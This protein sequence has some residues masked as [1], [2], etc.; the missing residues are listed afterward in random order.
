MTVS[1]TNR[2]FLHAALLIA[3]ALVF[4]FLA[5]LGNAARADQFAYVANEGTNDV[6]IVDLDSVTVVDTVPVGH[7][8]VD[9]V[10]HPDGSEVYV[11]GD[12]WLSIIDAATRDAQI[13][14][15]EFDH[16]NSVVID[17]AGEYVYIA[18]ETFSYVTVF[19][20]ATGIIDAIEV[21]F[22][23]TQHMAISPIDDSLFLV[24]R[25]GDILQVDTATGYSTPLFGSAMPG[26]GG[27]A[28]DSFGTLYVSSDQN[29]SVKAAARLGSGYSQLMTLGSG[30]RPGRVRIDTPASGFGGIAMVVR[31]FDDT[32]SRY[33]ESEIRLPDGSTPMDVAA[34][35]ENDTLVIAFEADLSLRA[36]ARHGSIAVGAPPM[37]GFN[38][39]T[40][41]PAGRH[42]IAVAIGPVVEFI[43]KWTLITTEDW[44]Y[45]YAK[46]VEPGFVTLDDYLKVYK[47]EVAGPPKA[48]TLL[49]I[50]D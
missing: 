7:D 18:H 33:F 48:P 26:P 5:S 12:E 43:D 17:R 16:A 50:S 40:F 25:G 11:V 15:L 36:P 21:P 10:V 27:I 8:P 47:L 2:R 6:T 9:L 29:L 49:R 28:V 14:R 3:A 13:I 23:Q 38:P 34:N 44:L 31:P 41:L 35:P 42:P 45:K 46:V 19:E 30:Y 22:L 32:I 4:A 20:V 37:N 39:P 1:Q 24:N